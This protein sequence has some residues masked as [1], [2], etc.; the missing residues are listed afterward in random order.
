[1]RG[2][3][4]FC[5][6]SFFMCFLSFYSLNLRTS[7]LNFMSLEC[8]LFCIITLSFFCEY[9]WK[10]L[11]SKSELLDWLAPS[12]T[13]PPLAML[14]KPSR[15]MLLDSTEDWAWRNSNSLSEMRWAERD[16]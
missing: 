15:S 1:M 10:A 14:G 16:C 12:F 7:S 13:C 3:N 6:K 11:R 2:E 4:L 5:L 9:C 8:S